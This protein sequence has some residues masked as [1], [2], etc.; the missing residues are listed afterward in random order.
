MQA[1]TSSASHQDAQPS[2]DVPLDAREHGL[3]PRLVDEIAGAC[4][5]LVEGGHML[6]ITRPQRTARFIEDAAAG[7]LAR[8]G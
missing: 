5:E 6:P 3:A 2:G 4:P 7:Q 1:P 8:A